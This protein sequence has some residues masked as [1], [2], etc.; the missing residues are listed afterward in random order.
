MGRRRRG[1]PVHGWLVLD[2][3]VGPTSTDMVN[4]ARR[5][6]DA[7]KAGHAGTLDP[8]ASGILPIAFGEATK[9]VPLLNDATKVYRFTVRWGVQTTTDDAEGE[10]LAE[11][12][13][14]P[15][16]AA[17][18]AALATFTGRIMQ[19]PPTFSAIKVNGQRA[20]DLARAGAPPDLPPREAE[21][22]GL[23][24]IDDPDP[25]H[26]RFE[27]RSGKGVYVR[28]LAR[29]LALALGA[30]GHVAELRRTAVGP[31]RENTAISLDDFVSLCDKRAGL[32]ALSPIETA[33]DDIPA[34]ALTGEQADRLRHGQP[35]RVLNFTSPEAELLCVTHD[36]KP[37]A[38]ARYRSEFVEPV[39]VFNL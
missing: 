3:P 26:S 16:P 1:Q 25:D 5:L 34:L 7:Q 37:V 10:A 32:E 35:V 28:S 29:D 21:I 14:R 23:V 18:G 11:S 36:R 24:H 33:L 13:I 39:R 15:A 20:Y 12:D 22:H 4:R 27:M 19:T 38:L 2:K 8:L 6:L 9:C 17:I 30:R 31:F